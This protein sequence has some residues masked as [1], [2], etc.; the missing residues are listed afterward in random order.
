[1]IPDQNAQVAEA[2]AALPVEH[3]DGLSQLRALILDVAR[4]VGAAPVQE[5]LRWGQPS[6]VSA[7]PRECTTIRLGSTRDRRHF[8]LF[9]HCQSTVLQVFRSMFP[10]EFRYDGN[11]AILFLPGEDLQKDKL[12]LCIGH[13]LQYRAT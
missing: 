3:R 5:M 9:I 11:R 8:A 13:A 10:S 7:R 6:Y 12:R 4:D 1:M 2:F